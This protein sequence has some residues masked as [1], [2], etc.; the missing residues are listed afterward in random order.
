MRAFKNRSGHVDARRQWKFAHH[1]PLT[2]NGQT[3]LV[4]QRA[5]GDL[6]R[7][8]AVGQCGF[9]KLLEFTVITG[10]ILVDL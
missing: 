4:V 8:I 2:G 9:I 1:W 5:P 6:N 7:H 3:I 10:V